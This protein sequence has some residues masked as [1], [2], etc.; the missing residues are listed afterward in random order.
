MSIIA[1]GT[2]T[3]TALSSTGNTDG[4]L[5]LQVNGTTPSIT[6]NTLG[7]IGVGST[8]S[9]GTAGQ[10]LTS[11]GST[12]A[13]TW[14]SVGSSQWTTSGSDIYYN[15][16]NVSI[17]TTTPLSAQAGRTDLTVNGSSN[18]MVSLG[19]GGTRQGYLYTP[20]TGVIL[21]SENAELNLKTTSGQAVTFGTNNTERMRVNSGAPILC[22][23]GGNTSATGTGI[24]FPATQSASSDANTLDDYEEGTWTPA[25]AF[26][27]GSTGLT[28]SNQVGN[29]TK[30]GNRVFISGYVNIANKGSSTGNL[31]ITG[32]PFTSSSTSFM[33][34]S[35]SIA[36]FNL[37]SISGSLQAYNAPNTS[38]VSEITYLGTGSHT[39]VTQ[40]NCIISS[41]FMINFSYSI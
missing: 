16:G 32:L 19:V 26:G 22:L 11:G 4:T 34:N 13:P 8:P 15:T 20:S 38:T 27:G 31:T 7:A 39:A 14:S 33:Y 37:T 18:A 35:M 5:Q 3:T 23:S 29:Y 21:A 10:V 41:G 36:A 24:A 2:T 9:Y 30:I 12:A 1:A 17:G 40:A 25:L 6:L 28:Y